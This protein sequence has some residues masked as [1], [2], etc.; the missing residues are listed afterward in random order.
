MVKRRLRDTCGAFLAD[1]ALRQRAAHNWFV[2][3]GESL[4]E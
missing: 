3:T 1:E 4:P 2:L